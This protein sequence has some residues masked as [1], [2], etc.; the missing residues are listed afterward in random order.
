MKTITELLGGA[1]FLLGLDFNLQDCFELSLTDDQRAFLAVLQTL[2]D[3][4]PTLERP[5]ARTG[6][7][8]MRNEPFLRAF[9]A[10]SFFAIPTTSDLIKRL[11]A[12]PN[13][14]KLCAFTSVPSPAVFSRRLAAFSS[15]AVLGRTLNSLVTDF[16]KDKI[17]GHISR[18]STAIAARE[19]P[20][21]KKGDATPPSE[22]KQKRGRPRKGTS[23]PEKK[24]NRLMRQIKMKP[25]KAFAELDSACA[26]G[27]KKNSQG[28]VSFWKGYKLHLDV[29]DR[30]IPVTAVVTGA[31]VHDSQVAIPMEKWT[32]RKIDFL[33]SVMDSAYDAAPIAAYIRKK[34]RVPLIDPNKRRGTERAS[35]S[36][37]QKERFT[38]RTSVER[39]NAHLKD[40]LVPPQIFVKGIK[41]VSFVL[42]CGVLVLAALKI[43][44]Y[45]TPIPT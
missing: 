45:S 34:G 40:R 11:K 37:A 18:D 16:H 29:T 10:K 44:L 31:N 25:G 12:D 36:P 6:R 43:L 1:Q 26:W 30:G 14:K 27:C 28:N 3:H 8:P 17:V 19:K 42:E 5:P 4:L 2:S 13:L 39:A 7:P 9:L 15:N 32:E 41:K 22:Q 38:I 35:F 33:Y 20:A 23:R 21:N 24:Q